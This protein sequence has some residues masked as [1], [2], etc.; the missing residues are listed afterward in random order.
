MMALGSTGDVFL[1]AVLLG[2]AALDLLSG[3]VAALAMVSVVGR[4]GTTSLAALAGGQAVLGAAG[5]TG[6]TALVASSWAGAAA[7]VLACP[8]GWVPAVAFGAAAAQLVA[9]PALGDGSSAGLVALRVVGPLVGMGLCVAVAQL[10][11]RLF[12]ARTAI[13]AAGGA[14]AAAA[15]ALALFS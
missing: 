13:V 9:G 4:W 1:L 8:E 15:A 2:L 6:T 14:L 5:W 10:S 7:L 11:R 12:F 3:G